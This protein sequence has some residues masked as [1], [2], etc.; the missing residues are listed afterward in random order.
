M[1]KH[2]R[3][4]IQWLRESV[5]EY[6]MS[7]HGLAALA[8]LEADARALWAVR[9]LDAWR[10]ALHGR[11]VEESTHSDT[12]S[13]CELWD[14]EQGFGVTEFGLRVQEAHT[15]A[16]PDAARIA[17]ATALVAADPSLDPDGVR[18]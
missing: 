17:A 8:V 6:T 5:P 3:N 16:D 7:S 11:R 14:N 10:K 18:T 9:V 13:L 15:G 1:Q 4:A 2:Q 12:C